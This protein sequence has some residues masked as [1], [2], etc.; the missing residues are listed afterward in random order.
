M[1]RPFES[2]SHGHLGGVGAQTKGFS[3]LKKTRVE[4]TFDWISRI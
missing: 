1:Y 3:E 4:L 2:E